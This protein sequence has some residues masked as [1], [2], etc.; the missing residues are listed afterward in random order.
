MLQDLYTRHIIRI[1]GTIIPINSSPENSPERDK[2]TCRSQ[3]AK[4]AVRHQLLQ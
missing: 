3:R 4:R 2:R 1:T